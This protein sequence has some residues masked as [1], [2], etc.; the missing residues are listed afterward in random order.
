[1]EIVILFLDDY[2]VL[3]EGLDIKDTILYILHGSSQNVDNTDFKETI[4]KA[5][6]TIYI[7][8]DDPDDSENG[9]KKIQEQ[10]EQEKEIDKI[11]LCGKNHKKFMF[12]IR[13]SLPNHNVVLQSKGSLKRT[14]DTERNK[15]KYKENKDNKANKENYN[16]MSDF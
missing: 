3:K 4:K 2:G 9:L 12:Y 8:L 11:F 6:S 14:I 16:I 15:N 13:E 5:K 10:L 1:M 7:P